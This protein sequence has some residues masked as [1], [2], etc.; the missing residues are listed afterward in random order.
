LFV[1]E[2]RGLAALPEPGVPDFEKCGAW[3]TAAWR[4]GGRA[5]ILS[6]M[7]YHVFVQ[8]FRRSGRWALTG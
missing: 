5:Y 7:R 3:R 6:G 2:H 1:T 8:K 4:Q